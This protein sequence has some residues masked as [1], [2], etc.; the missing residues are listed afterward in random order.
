MVMEIKL[1]VV[2]GNT[3][4]GYKPWA[5]YTTSQGV[6]GGLINGGLISGW[7]YKWYIKYVSE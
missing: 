7:A 6:L 1:L 2:V 4:P 3:F 5:F